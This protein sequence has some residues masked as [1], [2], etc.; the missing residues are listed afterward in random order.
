MAIV[1]IAAIAVV[2]AAVTL[3]SLPAAAATGV[4]MATGGAVVAGVQ[5]LF[6]GRSLAAVPCLC[7]GNWWMITIG[8][9]RPGVFMYFGLPSLVLPVKYM[10]YN[11]FPP[12]YQLGKASGFLTCNSLVSGTCTPIGA[13]PIMLLHGTSPM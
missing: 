9:P 13:G 2:L 4:I 7:M 10:W 5:I 8:P 6:G 3:A 11:I 12:A 1:A